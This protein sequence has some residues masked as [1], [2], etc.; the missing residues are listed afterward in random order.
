MFDQMYYYAGPFRTEGW[1]ERTERGVK[2]IA[3]MTESTQ[4]KLYISIDTSGYDPSEPVEVHHGCSYH[5]VR[6]YYTL[7][8]THMSIVILEENDNEWPGSG[9]DY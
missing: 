2:L 7:S 5:A 6:T 8:G 9:T 1:E 3:T 4:S